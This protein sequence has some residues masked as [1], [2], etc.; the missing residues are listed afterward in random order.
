MKGR[1]GA[2]WAEGGGGEKEELFSLGQVLI[3]GEHAGKG[4]EGLV[5]G[6]VGLEGVGEAI[7]VAEEEVTRELQAREEQ[8]PVP[9]LC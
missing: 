4:V 5:R 3:P 2:P 1:D 8:L 7:G 9:L 6:L